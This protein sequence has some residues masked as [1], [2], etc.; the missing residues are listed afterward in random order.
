MPDVHLSSNNKWYD[1][2][3]RVGATQRNGGG[4]LGAVWH[5]DQ[6]NLTGDSREDF[7]SGFNDALADKDA[8]LDEGL[9]P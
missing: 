6:R 5:A 9:D 3:Y 8:F 7:T 1:E 4:T 2:G